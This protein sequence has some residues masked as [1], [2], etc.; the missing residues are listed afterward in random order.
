M[1]LLGFD[2][3]HSTWG[4]FIARSSSTGEV[5]CWGADSNKCNN[6]RNIT[7]VYASEE[8]VIALDK[9]SGKAVK[10]V[11]W[12]GGPAGNCEGINFD[13]VTDIYST[14]YAFL[15]LNRNSGEAQ[16]W[17]D[18][19]RGGNCVDLN[20]LGMADVFRSWGMFL[21]VNFTSGKAKCWGS[22]STYY[23]GPCNILDV[24]GI[25]NIYSS[26]HAFVAL[27]KDTG[28]TL[29]WGDLGRGGSC[30]DL[31]GLQVAGV[32]A[33]R[34]AFMALAWEPGHP[35]APE[36]RAVGVLCAVI[37]SGGTFV[38][39]AAVFVLCWQCRKQPNPSKALPKASLRDANV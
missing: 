37:V 35:F 8:S 18:P 24:T 3:V 12:G 29:C 9:Q 31:M 26:P 2:E 19:A 28:R 22:E 30:P 10:A 15:A 20:L 21:A 38:V 33:S 13:S 36:R 39:L 7:A 27:N 17:G 25:T 14:R 5:K 16:C 34:S 23:G 6:L 1:S 32:Y 11:C 4:L